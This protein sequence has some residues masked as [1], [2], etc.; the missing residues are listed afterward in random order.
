MP[1]SL[2]WFWGRT[3]EGRE[4]CNRSLRTSDFDKRPLLPP[5]VAIAIGFDPCTLGLKML[6][7]SPSKL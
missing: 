5:R 4:E 3:W 1:A 2:V 7:L 6:V